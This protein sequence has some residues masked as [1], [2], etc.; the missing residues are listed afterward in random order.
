MIATVTRLHPVGETV[1]AQVKRLMAEAAVLAQAN[2]SDVLANA[3]DLRG[4]LQEI[5]TG[6]EVYP[7]GVRQ[8][9]RRLSAELA[10]SIQTM[11]AI[12]E[13]QR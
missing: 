8:E 1:P 11:W 7:A 9:A 3:G 4:W 2:V 5:E 13:R 12:M 6:G 10:A